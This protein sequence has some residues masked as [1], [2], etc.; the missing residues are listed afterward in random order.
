MKLGQVV[1]ALGKIAPLALAAEW[2][3]VG[4]L[5]EPL[6]NADVRRVL[7]T[8]DLTPT[9]LQEAQALHSDLIVAYHPPIFSG[10]KSLTQGSAMQR[11]VLRTLAAGIAV[12][13]P[14]T[15][16]D[17][18]SGGLNDWLADGLGSGER[19][20]LQPAL[21][22]AKSKASKLTVQGQGRLVRLARPA[23]L[24]ELLARIKRH[25]DLRRLR[26]ALDSEGRH[27]RI[28]TVALCAGA[29]GS[30][31]GDAQADLLLTGEMRHHDVLAAVQ[32]NVAV[33]LTEHSNS[34]RGYLPVLARTL[35]SQLGK[36][37]EIRVARKD[38]EP[39]AIL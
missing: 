3:N 32:R 18:V 23:K 29:G 21:T 2:D 10:V 35:K 31:I 11:T 20:A 13:S 15:A 27:K 38:Y 7:L 1:S 34:E 8:V 30:V 5:L 12:Y 24:S 4:L 16:L 6:P 9:V 37:V 14:H 26:V 19:A 17:A 33:V 36:T 22:T 25:L 39:L 28:S